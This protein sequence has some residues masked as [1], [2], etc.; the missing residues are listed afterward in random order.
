MFY[1]IPVVTWWIFLAVVL[2]IHGYTGSFLLMNAWHLTWL[3]QPMY[4]ISMLGDSLL[5]GALLVL[6]HRRKPAMALSF[7]LV[8]VITGLLAQ[9]LKQIIFPGWDRPLKLIADEGLVH[10]VNNVRLMHNSFP[11]GH[12]VS[13][14]AAFTLLAWFHKDKISILLISLF[15]AVL[16]PYTRVYTGAHFPGDVLAGSLIGSL[17]AMVMIPWFNGIEFGM[18]KKSGSFV[19]G[20]RQ[21]LVVLALV[22][23][24]GFVVMEMW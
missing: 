7:I 6:L 23:L 20:L 21:W 16:V 2:T 3:D 18:R 22:G 17:C 12:S 1:T 15:L 5:L 13:A 24:V 10:V 4:Y 11:S 14:G 9:F 8:L 19:S